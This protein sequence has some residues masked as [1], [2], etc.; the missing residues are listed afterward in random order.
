MTFAKPEIVVANHS[1]H[2]LL[3]SQPIRGI[4]LLSEA[5]VQHTAFY[6]FVNIG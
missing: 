6:R 5:R 2:A 4:W 1:C 3:L